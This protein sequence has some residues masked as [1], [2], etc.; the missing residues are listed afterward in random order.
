MNGAEEAAVQAGAAVL[1]G[2]ETKAPRG[3]GCDRRRADHMEPPQEAGACATCLPPALPCG[4]RRRRLPHQNQLAQEEKVAMKVEAP[5][6]PAR[7]SV[8][9]LG[10]LTLCDPMDCSPPGSSVHGIL[11]ARILE[12]VACPPPGDLPDPVKEPTS[13]TSPALAGEFFTTW[14]A[15]SPNQTRRQKP[16]RHRG[17]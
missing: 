1:P 2:A 3:W 14:K 10:C 13:L 15:H 16:P 4:K 6:K 17:P 11:Q 5:P 12:W 7:T 8:C 9:V